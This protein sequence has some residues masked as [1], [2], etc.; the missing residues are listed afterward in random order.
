MS[1]LWV[2]RTDDDL[3]WRWNESQSGQGIVTDNFRKV[4]NRFEPRY[5]LGVVGGRGEG[6]ETTGAVG[7]LWT[8][9]SG[10]SWELGDL[11]RL[12]D[13]DNND[14]DL[15]ELSS[16][17]ETVQAAA[18]QDV[19]NGALPTLEFGDYLGSAFPA[20]W[21]VTSVDRFSTTDVNSTVPVEATHVGLK[22]P[23][24]NSSGWQIDVSGSTETVEITK[25]DT[26]R[27]RYIV[28][29][30]AVGIQPNPHNG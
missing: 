25:V 19:V 8:I 24:D 13:P 27:G 10:A 23:L 11:L 12:N 28:Q 7:T 14:F 20:I 17:T 3:A 21:N 1:F 26:A 6:R 18:A 15:R 2:A 30:L 5:G 4:R 29:F 22:V 16:T 9:T